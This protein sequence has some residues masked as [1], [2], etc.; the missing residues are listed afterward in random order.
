MPSSQ[1]S[2][3][4]SSVPSVNFNAKTRTEQKVNVSLILDTGS[5]RRMQ[6]YHRRL[7]LGPLTA[8]EIVVLEG[9]LFNIIDSSI[10]QQEERLMDVTIIS[11]TESN[12]KL[13]V[14]SEITLL[15]LCEEENCESGTGGSTLVDSISSS[16]DN[17]ITD[18]GFDAELQEQASSCASCDLSGVTV[19]GSTFSSAVVYVVAAPSSQP[20]V[21]VQPSISSNPSLNPSGQPSGNPTS[22]PS[23]SPSLSANSSSQPPIPCPAQGTISLG[24]ACSSSCPDSCATGFVCDGS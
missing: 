3:S 5:G 9:A 23:E 24:D 17:T 6:T 13:T 2:S 15:Q 11:V 21:S 22:Q 10:N 18:G 19:E 7:Q 4:P 14:E 1:P 16:V 12:G 8:E 20:S